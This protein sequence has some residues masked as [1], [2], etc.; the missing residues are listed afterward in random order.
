[1]CLFRTFLRRGGGSSEE[2]PPPPCT[3]EELFVP[4]EQEHNAVI[5]AACI[6]KNPNQSGVLTN[7]G[8]R[9]A[10]IGAG[11]FIQRDS[12]ALSHMY[13]AVQ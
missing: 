6:S 2:E 9:P 8:V 4:S 10:A 13:F 5:L 7:A 11:A 12:H 1:M 3:F